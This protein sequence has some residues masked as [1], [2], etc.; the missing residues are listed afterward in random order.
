MTAGDD[1]FTVAVRRAVRP[2]VWGIISLIGVVSLAGGITIGALV[3]Q[4]HDIKATQADIV[5]SRTE[6][7]AGAC[8]K[9]NA[10][11]RAAGVAARK[12]AEDFVKLQYEATGASF[13]QMPPKI[14]ALTLRFYAEQEQ[15]TLDSYPHRD[16]SSPAAI[17]AFNRSQPADPEPCTPAPG[18]LCA[19]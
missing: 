13:E 11:R 1:D 12:K 3:V 14:Q 9:D 15:V 19:P 10:I 16:C 6:A 17:A 2:V 5:V 8:R 4:A 18:G 7:A